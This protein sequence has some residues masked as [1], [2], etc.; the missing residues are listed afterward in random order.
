MNVNIAHQ[1][2]LK[3]IEEINLEKQLHDFDKT[4]NDFPLYKWANIYMPQ[5]MSLLNF[6]SSIKDP[7]IYMYLASLENLCKYFFSYNRLDYALNIT[8]YLA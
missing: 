6:M 4:H 7:Y 1:K 5:V 8:V 3:V 2:V